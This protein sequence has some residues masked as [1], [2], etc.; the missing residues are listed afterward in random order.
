[1]GKRNSIMPDQLSSALQINSQ[2]SGGVHSL[3]TA[4]TEGDDIQGTLDGPGGGGGGIAM[5]LASSM[6]QKIISK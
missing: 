6:Q 1:M 3:P 4:N 5:G 2:A